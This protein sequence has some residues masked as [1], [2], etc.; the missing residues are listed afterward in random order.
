[1][2]VI[3]TRSP[4]LLPGLFSL[5]L[6]ALILIPGAG[7]ETLQEIA[8]GS[9]KPSARVKAMRLND[10]TLDLAQLDFDVEVSN[11]YSVALPLVNVD[12][13]IASAGAQFLTGAAPISGSVP[14][15]GSKV[16][17]VPAKV[18]FAELFTVLEGIRPGALVPYTADFDLSVNAP[19]LGPLNL[20]LKKE[21]EFPVP[22]VPTVKLESVD[23]QNLTL[24]EAAAVLRIK[25]SNTNQFPIDLS[26]FDFGLSLAGTRVAGT[27][28]QEGVSFSAGGE[29]VLAIPIAI[30]PKDLGLAAFRMLA[31][32]GAGYEL[33]GAMKVDTPFGPIDFPFDVSGQT[34]F[35]R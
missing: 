4:G 32:D 1:M 7:C 11:P 18:G 27:G 26:V 12:Y 9:P 23:W 34:V 17:T 10:L 29:N 25:I 14:A 16:I 8:E 28:L 3:N 5:L 15:R 13:S 21:G 6:S 24:D 2:N 30:K 35:K 20:P 33:G 22:A 19:G 31:G